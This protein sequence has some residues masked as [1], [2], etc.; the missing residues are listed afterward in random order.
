MATIN[1]DTGNNTLVGT[2]DSDSIN[3]LQGMDTMTGLA[4][5]DTYV[6][7]NAGDVVVETVDAEG[8]EEGID[9]IQSSVTYVLP[10]HVENL[11]LTGTANLNGTGNDLNNLL[12]GNS[13]NNLLDGSAGLDTLHG[14]AG[15]DTYVVDR[16]EDVVIEAAGEGTDLVL[17]SASHQLSANVENLTLT[18]ADYIWGYGNEGANVLIGNVGANRLAGGDGNDTVQ[19][20]DGNDE[21]YG[22]L[23]NDSLLGGYGDDYL[24]GGEG[25]DSLQGGSGSDFLA[26]DNGEDFLNGEAGRDTL[27]GGAG[28]DRLFAGVTNVVIGATPDQITYQVDALDAQGDY[29]AG[30]QGADIL[31]SGNSDDTIE[32]GDGANIIYASGGN[33]TITGGISNYVDAGDGNDEVYLGS[34]AI[35]KGGAGNDYLQAADNLN[36][37]DGG[38]G[39]DWIVASGVLT[40]GSGDD[41]FRVD[42]TPPTL[43]GPYDITDFVMGGS[44]D[45]IDNYRLLQAL[46]Q[47]GFDGTN[48]GQWLRVVQSG[49]DT[50]FQVDKTGPGDG[51][52]FQTLAILRNTNATSI[53]GG[54][55][56]HWITL[57]GSPASGL[58][59]TVSAA[60]LDRTGTYM[61]RDGNDALTGLNTQANRID[62]GLGNDTLIGQGWDDVLLGDFGSDSLSGGAGRDLLVGGTGNDTLLGGDGDDGW[63][64]GLYYK[65]VQLAEWADGLKGEEG[66]D[67][68][69]GGAGNDHLSGGVGNDA[70]WG[71]TGSDRLDG[72]TGQDTLHGD[73]GNDEL[74]SYDGNDELY[75]EDGNDSIHSQG[76][77]NHLEGGAGND[78]LT[79]N[80]VLWFSGGTGNYLDGGIGDDALRLNG[81][82]STVVGG[83]GNDLI[84]VWG[85]DG[86][87]V[88][89]GEGDNTLFLRGSG[90]TVISGS[91]VDHVMVID[92]DSGQV[93]VGGGDDQVRL[94]EE[95][96]GTNNTQALLINLGD[97][98]D[99]LETEHDYGYY[100]FST[101]TAT[102]TTGAGSDTLQVSLRAMEYGQEALV[103][104]DFTV[105]AGGDRLN[106]TQTLARLHELGYDYSNPFT[107]GW[108][109]FMQSGEDTLLQV[110][111]DGTGSIEGWQ[112][113]VILR[114]VQAATVDLGLNLIPP[115]NG[116]GVEITADSADNWIDEDH[117]YGA[118]QPG[119]GNDI[120]RGKEGNDLLSG[121]F[122]GAD[123]LE[124]GQGDDR[125]FGFS[126]NDVLY[127]DD[128]VGGIAGGVDALW[129]GSGDDRLYG[130][131]GD[132]QYSWWLF[133]YK[134]VEYGYGLFGEAGNDYLDGGAGNDNLDGGTD[135]DELH[136]GLGDD[137]LF[138][139]DGNDRLYGEE[140]N[141]SLNAGGN[142]NR[143]EGGEGNDALNLGADGMGTYQGGNGNYL[144]GGAGDD[145]I[146]M[147]GGASTV[148]GGEG[149]DVIDVW[150]GDGNTV[151]AGEGD[152]T[153][154]LRGSGHTVS[155]GSGVDHVMVIDADSGQVSVGRGDDQVRLYE[156][157]SGTNNTQALLINLGDGADVLETEHDYGYYG[158]STGTA[159]V[160]TGEGS[161]TLQ[162]S[163]RAMEYGQEALVVTDFTVGAGGDRLN[164]TQTLARLHELG[165]DYSNPFTHGWLRFT[166]SG[167]DT[168][169][170]ADKDGSGSNEGWLTLAVL[171]NV[172]A[173]AISL[174][175]NLIPS[176]SAQ[177]MLVMGDSGDNWID[178]DHPYSG[179]QPGDGNDILRGKEGNDLLSGAFGGAD[180][181]EGGQGDD[182]L[183][184]FSGNDVLYGDDE[185]GGIAGGVDALWGGSGDDRLYGGEGDDRWGLFGYKGVEYGYGL[186]GEAGNDY[187]DGGAGNDHLDGG[188]DQ[189]ELH[190]GVGDDALF[191]NDGNDELYGEDGNDSIHSQGSNN[192]LEGG[193]GNDELTSN[194]VL[195]FSGGTG[196]YLD[197]GIGDDALRL[198]GGAS[199]VVGGEGNDLIDVWGGDGNTVV[200]GEGDN[201]LF[202]RGSGHTVISGSGVDHVMVID[203][204]SG[205]VSVGGGDDQVRLYEE[206]SGT[207]NTQA[208]LINLGD[209]ADVL[210]TEHFYI[211]DGF[212]TGTATVTTG[213]GSDTLQVSLRAT[214][215]GQ[216]VLVVT[217]F[218]VGAGGDRLDLTQTLA[219]LHELGYDYSNPFTHGWLRFTQSGAD[220]LLQ[221]DKDSTAATESWQT[222]TI[223]RNVTASDFYTR[224]D[225]RDNFIPAIS[226]SGDYTANSISGSD[227][228]NTMIGRDGHDT[229][230]GNGGN[231]LLDGDFDG[232]DKLVGGTGRDILF[233]FNGNDTL[234]GDTENNSAMG[235]W[236]IIWGGS[237][238][239]HIYGGDGNDSQGGLS[240]KGLWYGGG[241]YGEEGNDT[242]DGGDGQDY[243]DGGSGNDDLHGGADNDTLIAGSGNDLLYGGAGDDTLGAFDGHDRLEGGAGNDS[244]TANGVANYLDGGEDDDTI[245]F[246]GTGSTILGG[247]GAD[248][249]SVRG[250]GNTV[251]AGDGSDT[252]WLASLTTGLVATGAGND[253]VLIHDWWSNPGSQGLQ[254]NLGDGND[255]VDLESYYDGPGYRFGTATITTGTG[256][257]VIELSLRGLEAGLQPVVITDFTTGNSG[258]KLDMA[259]VYSRLQEM[260]WDGVT[261]P[262]TAG[263]LRWSR[264][265]ST[266]SVLEARIDGTSTFQTLAILQNTAPSNL[267]AANFVQGTTPVNSGNSIPVAQA[268]K[269]LSMM[270][271][272]TAT[273]LGL[274]APS[275]PDGGAVTIRVDGLSNHGVLRLSN[276]TEVAVGQI[277]TATQLTGLKFSPTA[278]INSVQHGD[279]GA[280]R[281]TVIDNEGSAIYREVRFEITPVN[282]TPVVTVD[283]HAILQIR[284]DDAPVRIGDLINE[285]VD[286]DDSPLSSATVSIGTPVAGDTLNVMTEG[287]RITATY[288][289]LTGELALTGTDSI[290]H[291]YD[292]LR[293]L[294]MTTLAEGGPATRVINIQ[295]NDGTIN[296]AVASFNVDVLYSIEGTSGHDMITGTTG[297]DYLVGWAGDDWLDGM[298]G[299][300]RLEG[301]LGNDTYIVDETPDTIIERPDEGIDTVR[302]RRNDSFDLNWVSGIE[303]LELEEGSA[304]RNGFGSAQNNRIQGNSANNWLDGREGADTL[305][306]GLGDDGYH[307]DEVGDSVVELENEGLDSIY[308]TISFTLAAHLENLVLEGTD[309]INGTGNNL[310]NLL[311]GNDGWNLLAGGQGND[312]YTVGLGDTVLE[313]ASQGTDTL[314]SALSW[315]L[316]ANLENLTLTGWD[317]IDGEG[318]SLDN[319]L[320]GN[321]STNTLKGGY[322]NDT[323]ILD[324]DNTDVI[325]EIA[326]QGTD[327]VTAAFNYTLADALEN[328]TL[329]G[330]DA[331]SG[332]GNSAKNILTGNS[333][334]NTLDGGAAGDTLVG[335]LGDDSYIIDSK[336]DTVIELADEGVDTLST[337]LSRTLVNHVENLTLTGT[338]AVNGN[339][340]TL[341][342]VLTGN[343]AANTL[344]GLDGNDTLI[345]LEGN[346]TLDGGLGADS[347]TGGVG[348]DTYL[349]NEAG[350]T[351]NENAAE[352]TDLVKSSIS[353]TLGDHLENLT[354]TGNNSVAATGN[355][356]NNVLTGN[357]GSNI[358]NGN[359]GADTLAGGAGNDTYVVDV[360]TVALNEGLD[361]GTDTVLASV[362]WSLGNHLENLTLT[363]GNA[364]NGTGNAL[365]NTLSGNDAI[366]V[367]TGGDGDDILRG[368]GGNDTLDGGLGADRLAGGLGDDLYKV[369]NSGDLITEYSNEGTDTVQSAVTFTLGKALENLVL[370]G[371]LELNGTGNSLSN[372]LTG[373]SAAN[374]L[375]GGEGVDTL[376]G[377]GGNDTLD[378]GLG[379]DTLAGGQGDDLYM[380][381]NANDLI[382]EYSNE[383]TD[384]VQSAATFTLGK[385]L[386]NLL[387]TGNSALNATGNSMDNTLTGNSAANILTGGTGNDMLNGGLGNDTY[388]VA[389]GDGTDTVVDSDSTA[390]NSDVL[391]FL[392]GVARDQV[393]FTHVGNNL[394]VSIIGTSTNVTISNWYSGT[395][396]RVEQIKT[397]DGSATLLSG[398]VENLVSAMAAFGTRPAGATT[399]TAAE[400]AALDAVIAANWS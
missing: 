367:L 100:G 42:I 269:T 247:L 340:N 95:W 12:I 136:G 346:D 52:A 199:T 389:R 334:S 363:G 67:Y 278:N 140:G 123:V 217:D 58:N 129:G 70:L 207:N 148:V 210:E 398:N 118:L 44:E 347:L 399:L 104:T 373:N 231:D 99:V 146:R 339:G 387:L 313:S 322:G 262:Y 320:T 243:L 18:G 117:P 328:L 351:V 394:Q 254:V 198:N 6:V 319:I 15:N 266:V 214:E 182:R 224:S 46:R 204:D 29:L 372:Q 49:A 155:S 172:N 286:V 356:G 161:D 268:S 8:A 228:D 213:A 134:G 162:V 120:L 240:Y 371:A 374:V 336:W 151:V 138:S 282:D 164:L 68:L 80:Y 381:D 345:G 36:N 72:G 25:N 14:G 2:P 260:G 169:L 114:N 310:D 284:E 32:G 3:G 79:S 265:G 344:S 24:S 1:G 176:L 242:I 365:A 131:A 103:V 211:Y 392:G 16:F 225:A 216:E 88:V 380:V 124:G 250:N 325:I 324:G 276:N 359:G 307:V 20:M 311:V 352:G 229:F 189:D 147:N 193:A 206:R 110:D 396:N 255:W 302:S 157:W 159:T 333:N 5:N 142:S 56:S 295:V 145:T 82:A 219:R 154:F 39:D 196:N 238:D 245:S 395:A 239:D 153:L 54:D 180:V 370:T 51:T 197:G 105:G 248:Q 297:D 382:T 165:Y 178:E 113:L 314:R 77:N 391:S 343:S 270:E 318:N 10:V 171:R 299:T 273:A 158:F 267:V 187:L 256:S 388:V 233:G 11:T 241:L 34:S 296:S 378:G 45:S 194:Y 252:V 128:E 121:A 92:A 175:W 366:N 331:I 384:T 246:D 21:L 377:Y 275:D 132:D 349:V 355:N 94:Y 190:G 130:G 173:T 168:L 304:A 350:D 222:L 385:A 277:L 337:S 195:W 13:G 89:A 62:G 209:G 293:S 76:S 144:D 271:D 84:D 244:L 35:I 192:H 108:L 191:S 135:Q 316:G 305:L 61:G 17:A 31:I 220:T 152:N 188:T 283:T 329:T 279:S 41:F 212:S 332:T 78:E 170:Q 300:D 335:G 312:T 30:G 326:G 280:F 119:D 230:Y 66:N 166:Q 274:T 208:L 74:V 236:D 357:A 28:D 258:D 83:E 281:Y 127:G 272:A 375:T 251:D 27:D 47:V 205:Q 290:S 203:A 40:G 125:L 90:H 59:Q 184:G 362:N 298:E 202:L 64:G 23:G 353:W 386:E 315:T 390:G 126:G 263:Y 38:S 289:G 183:F 249:I 338:S 167:A 65:G 227:A 43:Y 358:L 174:K 303:N 96:S 261:N 309:N 181:L 37:I 342:N 69:D 327:L 71:G 400:H 354:L 185:V 341:A 218:T 376:R 9:L 235:D 294:T 115:M 85:G 186:F 86:N 73:I 149:N 323:Y 50:L 107:H 63:L 361:Q 91:G 287:T 291:Y 98:A 156:E 122:D 285:L 57:A 106:L 141:D 226:P 143:L 33:D 116:E 253:T 139:N 288:N 150:G 383:G 321:A 393:W 87:T 201:T 81:G 4:G 237:G 369:D 7:D 22:D 264:N 223:L 109:R 397:T 317:A 368:Y 234:Y 360:A 364:I 177:G 292:V 348:N 60:V 306:G 137:A 26:G 232:N 179:L 75:G 19:G 200:A 379:A 101:G 53:A 160:T 163:L 111:K 55:F 112:T 221:V 257:D 215:Y 102:V 259:P 330:T 133:G 308:S 48:V 301:G 93:S 97:G